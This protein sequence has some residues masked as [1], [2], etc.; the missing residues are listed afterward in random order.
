MTDTLL[1]LSTDHIRITPLLADDARALSAI[2][3]ESVT[4]QVHFLPTPFT[5]SDAR[6]LI[7][8]SG[9]GDV[10]HAVRDRRDAALLGV[11][12]VHRRPGPEYE[13]GYWFAAAARGRGL[14]T[15]AVG[16][17]VA[18]LAA[19]RPDCAIVAECR[20]ANQRSRALLLRLGFAA[21][22]EAGHRP[23]RMRFRWRAEP[24]YRFDVC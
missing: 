20:P 24:D 18:S 17:M 10:F 7:A 23:G 4:S 6:A 2:T 16:A 22:G 1:A 5:E 21:T 12:G 9:G 19:S 11:I 3:D 14:A 15:E 8:G 13:V